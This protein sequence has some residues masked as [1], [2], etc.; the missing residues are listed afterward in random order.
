[1]TIIYIVLTLIV[2]KNKNDDIKN[3]KKLNQLVGYNYP[4]SMIMSIIY[5][6]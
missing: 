5:I 2:I 3:C 4:Y 1:M 6:T